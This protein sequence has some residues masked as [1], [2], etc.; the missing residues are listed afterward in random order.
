MGGAGSRA[1]RGSPAGTAGAA[2]AGARRDGEEFL[3]LAARLGIR[4]ETTVYPFEHAD[5]ALEYLSVG[6]VRGAG[7][8]R[9]AERR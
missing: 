2:G 9:V 7:V 3:T 4:S 5:R 6:D 1:D 8:L